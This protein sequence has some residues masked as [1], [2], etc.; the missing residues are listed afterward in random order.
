MA[1]MLP[2][3]PSVPSTSQAEERLPA[4]PASTRAV[5][6]AHTW[7][8]MSE[9][10]RAER[11]AR[12]ARAADDRRLECEA[13]EKMLKEVQ[14]DILDGSFEAVHTRLSPLLGAGT[15]ETVLDRLIERIGYEMLGDALF[16]F[17]TASGYLAT[18][19]G[20]ASFAS[21]EHQQLI[22]DAFAV[23]KRLLE[24]FREKRA[25]A[26]LLLRS[27]LSRVYTL[28]LRCLMD[29]A[30]SQMFEEFGEGEFV[31]GQ[32]AEVLNYNAA[33]KR[34]EVR[35][36]GASAP[37]LFKRENLVLPDSIVAEWQDEDAKTDTPLLG[38]LSTDLDRINASIRSGFNFITALSRAEKQLVMISAHELGPMHQGLQAISRAN[39]VHYERG[40]LLEAVQTFESMLLVIEQQQSYLSIE[41]GLVPAA[42][43]EQ[44]SADCG[45]PRSRCRRRL[46]YARLQRHASKCIRHTSMRRE[47]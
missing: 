38:N 41:D 25:E 47:C 32:A 40:H 14:R 36:E 1:D 12:E 10:E 45:R 20:E 24:R 42:W 7:V 29:L 43:R 33:R 39:I 46:C 31:N 9:E 19:D 30:M 18:S 21:L 34:Y 4:A 3:E 8:E 23:C 5:T 27:L 2:V 22:V 15:E 37:M 26:S 28:Y 44:M 35:V 6:E 13:F 11:Q 16:F 17:S